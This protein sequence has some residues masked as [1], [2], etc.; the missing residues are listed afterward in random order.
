MA[1]LGCRH[2]PLP[3][4]LL[5]HEAQPVTLACNAAAQAAKASGGIRRCMGDAHGSRDVGTTTAVLST[6]RRLSCHEPQTDGIPWRRWPRQAMAKV[7]AGGDRCMMSTML[8]YTPPPV[9]R[10]AIAT[11]RSSPWRWWPRHAI[12]IRMTGG[13]SAVAESR[14]PKVRKSLPQKM[15][16]PSTSDNFRAQRAFWTTPS[17]YRLCFPSRGDAPG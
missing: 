6:L 13:S 4:H 8:S 12:A 16:R 1:R 10:L 17:L 15:S 7:T 3:C 11:Y 2:V 9:N 14:A 5:G